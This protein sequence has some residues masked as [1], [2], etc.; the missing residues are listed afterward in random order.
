MVILLP[1]NL[2]LFGNV[3]EPK[4]YLKEFYIDTAGNWMMEMIVPELGLI[5]DSLVVKTLSGSS[6]VECFESYHA[7]E[8]SALL[9]IITADSLASPLMINPDSDRINI[10]TYLNEEDPHFNYDYDGNHDY[11]SLGK[12]KGSQFPFIPE[13][14]SIT[15]VPDYFMGIDFLSLDKS[16]TLGEPNTIDGT[17]GTVS[18]YLYDK[19]HNPL[20]DKPVYGYYTGLH[21]DGNGYYHGEVLSKLY[22]FDYNDDLY[23]NGYYDYEPASVYVLPDSLFTLDLV[24]LDIPHLGTEE[25]SLRNGSMITNYPNPFTRETTFYIYIPADIVITIASLEILDNAGRHIHS[26]ALEKGRSAVTL[27]E[28]DFLMEPGVYHYYIKID[29]KARSKTASLVKL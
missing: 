1:V 21:T 17:K 26:F 10:I 4:A 9:I 13:K 12:Y 11:L 22:V 2:D 23:S 5:I 7:P 25:I 8:D 15:Y 14:H 20:P 27:S 6:S 3:L 16:P 18:G 19:N 28:G 29:G 24:L